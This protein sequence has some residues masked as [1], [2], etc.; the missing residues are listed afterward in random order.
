MNKYLTILALAFLTSCS[1]QYGI[2]GFR[3]GYTEIKLDD[4][5]YEVSFNGNGYTSG[6]QIKRYFLYRCAEL[7]KTNGGNYF[8]MYDKNIGAIK[9]SSTTTGSVNNNGDFNAT[10]S[11]ITKSYGSGII[12]IL[13]KKPN[14]YNGIIY[15]AKE[16]INSLEPYIKRGENSLF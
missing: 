1:T 7:T 4:N 8:V 10:T 3:G 12:E 14:D 5:L 2:S 11:T 15:D 6:T 16:L 9:T 13:K